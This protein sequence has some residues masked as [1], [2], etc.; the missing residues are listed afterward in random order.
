[1]TV[2]RRPHG[3]MA[4]GEHRSQ[5]QAAAESRIGGDLRLLRSTSTY[6]PGSPRL[7]GSKEDSG[8]VAPALF[9]TE[10]QNGR[11]LLTSMDRREWQSIMRT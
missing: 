9:P 8:L 3:R 7:L 1:M 6:K 2:E 5:P 10:Q 11:P 4:E